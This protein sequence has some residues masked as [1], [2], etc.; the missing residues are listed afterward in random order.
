MSEPGWWEPVRVL[1][2]WTSLLSIFAE[3]ITRLSGDGNPIVR[4]KP[5]THMIVCRNHSDFRI[6]M[7]PLCC[8]TAEGFFVS[9]ES[10][11]QPSSLLV[12]LLIWRMPVMNNEGRSPGVVNYQDSGVTKSRRGLAYEK[13][14]IARRQERKLQWFIRK[15]L[16]IWSS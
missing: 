4:L 16:R 13:M 10:C 14:I 15:F 5:G 11:K 7:L 8:I 1:S 12:W 2:I 6:S 9:N 3:I